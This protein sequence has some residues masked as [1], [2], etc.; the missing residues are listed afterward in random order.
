[1]K[2][3]EIRAE[4]IVTNYPKTRKNS[5]TSRYLDDIGATAETRPAKW[6]KN[7]LENEPSAI[8]SAYE[9]PVS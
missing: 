9:W 3:Q 6:S 7:Y 4:S 8:S 1:M 5:K 2:A